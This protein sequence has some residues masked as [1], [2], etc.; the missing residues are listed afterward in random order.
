MYA[1]IET[2]GKQYFLKS[3]DALY[4]E[5]V[6]PKEGEKVVFDKVLL[7]ANADGS[8]LQVGTPYLKDVTIE[9][10]VERQGRSKKIKVEKFKR[11][12]RYHKVYGHRQSYSKVKVK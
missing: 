7:T 4:I 2:G 12:I 5:K 3:G 10:E 6:A 11:K 8:N 1:V 9:A